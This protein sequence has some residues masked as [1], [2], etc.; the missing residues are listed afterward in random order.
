MC[1]KNCCCILCLEL[2]GCEK[3]VIRKAMGSSENFILRRSTENISEP[4][5][6]IFFGMEDAQSLQN[7]FEK[8][9]D[10][11][12]NNNN[13]EREPSISAETRHKSVIYVGATSNSEFPNISETQIV[14]KEIIDEYTSLSTVENSSVI[15]V[16]FKDTFAFAT[17]LV[18]EISLSCQIYYDSGDE[19]DFPLG[20]EA[21]YLTR[22]ACY[23]LKRKW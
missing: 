21:E 15:S 13:N 19:D 23:Y 18:N 22:S 16:I 5:K 12:N 4:K 1:D 8:K 20:M 17:Q 9:I 2:R 7:M 10:E 6:Y 11:N 14:R 3:Q